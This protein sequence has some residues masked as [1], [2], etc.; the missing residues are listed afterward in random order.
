[1]PRD[2]RFLVCVS[3]SILLGSI[4]YGQEVFSL[5]D[6]IYRAN[7]GKCV[8]IDVSNQ[9][10]AN[11]VFI[12]SKQNYLPSIT[13][14]NRHNLS[15][16]RVL[17][18]TTYQF[19][20]N[21]SVYDMSTTIGGSMTLFSGFERKNNVTKAKLNLQYALLETEKTK[22]DIALNVTALFL[23]IVL[24][25]EAIEVCKRKISMLEEQEGAIRKKL[26]YKVATQGDL[27]N[28][29]A[30]ITN[31][32]VEQS[33]AQN[34]LNVDKVSLC[35]LLE[36]EDWEN[37]DILIEDEDFDTVDLRLWSVSDVVSSAFQLP[38]IKQGELAID[39]AKSDVFIAQSS[40][41]PTV[42]LNAGYGSTFSNARTRPEG[43]DYNFRDQFRD[44]MSSYVTLS[45]N[46]PILSA[47]T[48]SNNVKQKKL[49]CTRA[50]YELTQAKLALDKEV[51]QAIVNA[52]TSYE[53]YTLLETEVNKCREALRQTQ[54]K[55]D[56][57]AATYYDYQIA[58]GNLFQA[59]AQQLQSK[60]EYI[61]RTKIIDFYAGESLTE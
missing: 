35:E 61:F 20:T 4:T 19:L 11:L 37:F 16:G 46:I 23:N 24:D 41:W 55:Y 52:N 54:T 14:S 29:Q 43:S 39:I 32:K 56:A 31:A 57:G 28:I 44:N 9:N 21:R 3:F 1:M 36:I 47:F 45:L 13:Y 2:I 50:E 26:E 48:T 12:Q 34:N 60:Y 58:V 38:Q 15:T 10:I 8:A 59:E 25:K 17:D 7:N 5:K 49:A 22:N 40:F 53:K 33:S 18:P 27:L 42:S 30:D 6:C 51:K